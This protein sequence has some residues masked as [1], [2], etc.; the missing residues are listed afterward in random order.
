MLY[1]F[2]TK[3]ILLELLHSV[4]RRHWQV[5][6]SPGPVSVSWTLDHI[7]PIVPTPENMRALK[8]I[9]GLFALLVLNLFKITN[10]P[11][12]LSNVF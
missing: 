8:S 3:L 7:T 9:A 2:R 11:E 1:R 12:T 6:C 5:T 10:F 4:L